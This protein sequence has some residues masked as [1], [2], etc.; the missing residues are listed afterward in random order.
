VADCV[1]LEDVTIGGEGVIVEIDEGKFGKRKNH[2]GHPVEGTWVVGGVERTGERKFLAVAVE[3]RSS[4]T[5]LAIIRRHVKPG[6]IIYT[7]MWKGYSGLDS[8]GTFQHFTVDHWKNFKD[9]VTGVNTNAIE[10]TWNGVKPRIKPRNRVQEGMD[11]HL[12][13]FIWRR[14]NEGQLWPGFI[15]ALREVFYE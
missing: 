9:P 11:E 3:N 6:S 10:G 15:A 12:W 2:R 4:D 1:E 5:L 7:D 13:E 14:K 8:D